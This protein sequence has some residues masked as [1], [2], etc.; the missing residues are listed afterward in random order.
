ML[1]YG[2]IV[3]NSRKQCDSVKLEGV[4]IEALRII[5][6]AKRFTSNTLL[7]KE[8]G[9]RTLESRRDSHSMIL[10]CKCLHNKVPKYLT[11]CMPDR[12]HSRNTR[13]AASITFRNMKTNSPQHQNSFFPKCT[14]SFNECDP[15]FRSSAFNIQLTFV[16]IQCKSKQNNY[17]KMGPRFIQVAL[18]QL[19]LGFSNLNEHLFSKGCTASPECGCSNGVETTKHYFTDCILYNAIRQELLLTLHTF[20]K[21]D[22]IKE[23]LN[24]ILQGVN[25]YAHNVDIIEAVAKFIYDSDRFKFPFVGNNF[26]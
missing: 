22:S 4:Q 23:V 15:R 25:V 6:G 17:Y 11:D 14:K 3:Y 13:S 8:T 12:L 26:L 10:F 21:D 20:T 7:L 2:N 9:F 1:E 19:R 16:Y 5:T 24:V 18:S